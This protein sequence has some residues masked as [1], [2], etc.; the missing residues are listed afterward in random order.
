MTHK[1]QEEVVAEFKGEVRR[2]RAELEKRDQKV[3]EFEQRDQQQARLAR[4]AVGLGGRILVGRPLRSSFHA[5]L[6]KK[7]LRDPLPADETADV[8]AAIVRRVVRVGVVGLLVTM[9]PAG[10]LLYQSIL[11]R[12]GNG[13]I[14][15]QITL[16]GQ[17]NEAIRRQIEQQAA[18]T[19]IVRRAQL[20]ATIY[21]EDCYDAEENAADNDTTQNKR[22]DAIC[23]P[24]AHA[25]AR[26]E[27][28]IAFSKIEQNRRVQPDLSRS[29]LSHLNFVGANLVGADL[30][31]AELV[32]ANL[33]EAELS[34]ADLTEANLSGANLSKVNLSRANLYGANLYGAFLYGA[35][36]SGA[37][38]SNASVG[39]RYE[40][41]A[42]PI[43]LWFL[44][45][46]LVFGQEQINSARGD[47]DTQLPPGLE[48]PENWL[49]SP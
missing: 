31:G 18:D 21:E 28:V 48:R 4:N 46:E 38:L 3:A 14:R 7:S 27:A 33:T 17:G 13:A 44:E 39:G 2:L 15:E 49:D 23:R 1:D 5:W 43:K 24:R 40:I 42:D 36:L 26:Q 35:N 47:T 10:F 9:V 34:R 45:A 41:R 22:P 19:L 37:D 32:G 30:R 11:M 25:R 6:K 29:N 20:L 8:L 12:Q 16:M